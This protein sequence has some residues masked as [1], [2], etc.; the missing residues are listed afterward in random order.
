MNPLLTEGKNKFKTIEFN[1]IHL[2]DFMPA[3][4]ESI[5]IAK[6]NIDKIK[7]IDWGVSQDNI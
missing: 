6:A 7:S 2:E 5:N 1:N 4:H 3:L